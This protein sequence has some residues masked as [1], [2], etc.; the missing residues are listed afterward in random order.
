[1][2]NA[3]A[4]ELAELAKNELLLRMYKETCEENIKMYVSIATFSNTFDSLNL[5]LYTRKKDQCNRCI[6]YKTKNVSEKDH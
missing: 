5:S 6:G 1:M 4:C 2:A 3:Q